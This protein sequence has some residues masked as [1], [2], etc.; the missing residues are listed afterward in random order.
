MSAKSICFAFVVLLVFYETGIAVAPPPGMVLVPS[1]EF[2]MGTD[3]VDQEGE[4]L[5]L[6][7][8]TMAEK[9]C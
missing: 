3:E 5:L 1:G 8:L 4:A 7:K 6:N 2:V 9:S